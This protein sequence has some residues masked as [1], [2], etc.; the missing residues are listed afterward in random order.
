MD[1]SISRGYSLIE[2]LRISLT[3]ISRRNTHSFVAL[4]NGFVKPLFV[5]KEKNV[6]EK[7]VSMFREEIPG[8]SV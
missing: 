1:I 6:Q 3:E 4:K 5:L 8:L 2:F 7:Y